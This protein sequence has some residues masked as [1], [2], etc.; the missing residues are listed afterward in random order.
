MYEKAAMELLHLTTR[1]FS[2]KFESDGRVLLFTMKRLKKT[3]MEMS[4]P[5][6]RLKDSWVKVKITYASYPTAANA[7][8]NKATK[9]PVATWLLNF[10]RTV[11]LHICTH[12]GGAQEPDDDESTIIPR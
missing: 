7:R 3:Q 9:T 1:L 8:M 6:I 2:I 4:S 11:G 12:H 5:K 10:N